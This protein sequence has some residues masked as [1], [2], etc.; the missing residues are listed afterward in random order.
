M[1]VGYVGATLMV[2]EVA[3]E[4]EYPGTRVSLRIALFRQAGSWVLC[5][6]S[7]VFSLSIH[8]RRRFA[9]SPIRKLKECYGSR[10][11]KSLTPSGRSMPDGERFHQ[12]LNGQFLYFAP[13]S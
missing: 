8:H 9:F 10:Q 3:V 12:Y 7:Q 11:R 5:F 6:A 13:I 4:E 1:F 2:F